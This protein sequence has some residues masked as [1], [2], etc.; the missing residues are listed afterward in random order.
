[1]GDRPGPAHHSLSERAGLGRVRVRVQD[2]APLEPVG[3]RSSLEAREDTH[4]VATL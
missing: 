4:I 3:S 1:M 2:D